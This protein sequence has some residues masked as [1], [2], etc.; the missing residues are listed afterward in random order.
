M[1][2][3]LPYSSN[4]GLNISRKENL[5]SFVDGYGTE[6]QFSLAQRRQ[7]GMPHRGNPLDGGRC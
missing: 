2:Y 4:G 1:K 7:R 6:A 5:A 3:S